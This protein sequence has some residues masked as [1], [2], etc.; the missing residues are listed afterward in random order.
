[1]RLG[2]T[3]AQV[4]AELASGLSTNKDSTSLT[5][6]EEKYDVKIVDEREELNT[7]NI[8]DYEFETTKTNDKGETKKEKHKLTLEWEIFSNFTFEMKEI[9]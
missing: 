6:D 8:M 4:Y 7:K 9:K 2:L 1:M 3:V 5:V